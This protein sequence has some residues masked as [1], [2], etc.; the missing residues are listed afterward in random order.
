MPLIIEAS[1]EGESTD[2][3]ATPTEAMIVAVVERQDRSVEERIGE[4][5]EP[6]ATQA[7]SQRSVKGSPSEGAPVLATPIQT[8][9]RPPL[10]NPSR[11]M[12]WAFKSS[13][14]AIWASVTGVYW[15]EASVPT[16]NA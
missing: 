3:T 11:S 12:F 8:K 7:S 2:A 10:A 13:A 15:P 16:Q 5:S 6:G 9:P 14:A 4:R 1:L